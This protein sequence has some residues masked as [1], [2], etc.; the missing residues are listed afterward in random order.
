M[1]ELQLRKSAVKGHPKTIVIMQRCDG[2]NCAAPVALPPMPPMPPYAHMDF[3]FPM[4]PLMPPLPPTPFDE[5]REL[6]MQRQMISAAIE[7]VEQELARM[8]M[9]RHVVLAPVAPNA[10]KVHLV[11]DH[12][13][14]HCESL[15]CVNGDPHRVVLQG[16]VRL[17]CKKCGQAVRIEAPCVVVNM[18]DGTFAVQSGSPA[19]HAVHPMPPVMLWTPNMHYQPAPAA[20]VVRSI[21][22]TLPGMPTTNAYRPVPA[23]TLPMPCPMGPVQRHLSPA[24]ANGDK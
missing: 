14:A 12:F 6:H 2:P 7:H 17:T 10:H 24:N 23:E 13:E 18:K 22:W 15:H 8:E 19:A 3:G 4:H 11:T 21:Q 9:Q 1:Q 20:D 16:D 5:L